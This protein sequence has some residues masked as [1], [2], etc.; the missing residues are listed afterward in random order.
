MDGTLPT[1][2]GEILSLESLMIR[3][4]D[5]VSTLPT[6]YG[7]LKNLAILLMENNDLTG[8][9]TLSHPVCIH[10]FTGVLIN[11]VAGKDINCACC[12]Q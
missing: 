11:F 9:I 1:E 7:N 2:Y 6:E 3:N 5:F 12:S 10:S 4:N 8:D